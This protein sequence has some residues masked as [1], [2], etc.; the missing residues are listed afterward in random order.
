MSFVRLF[1]NPGQSEVH[2]SG[3]SFLFRSVSGQ[4]QLVIESRHYRFEILRMRHYIRTQA[5]VQQQRCYECHRPCYCAKRLD[6][7]AYDETVIGFGVERRSKNTH[8]KL[9]A[10]C[11][12]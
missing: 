10:V 1:Q 4:H 8:T 12:G 5:H 11:L 9:L 7:D 2:V 3:G 6:E